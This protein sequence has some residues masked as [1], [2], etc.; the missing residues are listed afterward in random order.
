MYGFLAQWYGVRRRHF[1]A[2][3]FAIMHLTKVLLE[4]QS[5]ARLLQIRQAEE[6]IADNP[7]AHYTQ[8]AHRLLGQSLANP[9]LVPHPPV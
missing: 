1:S 6:Q 9:P 3:A 4:S 8:P 7:D 2:N 5:T